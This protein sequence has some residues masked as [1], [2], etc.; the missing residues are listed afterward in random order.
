MAIISPVITYIRAVFQPNKPSSR[1]T[2]T[3]LIMGAAIR[4]EKVTP[5]GTPDS[6]NP[7]NN[8]MAEHEQKG[9]TIP[10]MEAS[11]FPAK[12]DLPSSIFRVRSAEK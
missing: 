5:N 7:R 3:S 10:S 6:T 4:N 8:G 2:A 11:T 12:V 1:I 9:V